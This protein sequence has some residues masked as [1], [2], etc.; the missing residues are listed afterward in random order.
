MKNFKNFFSLIFMLKL[1][2]PVRDYEV[3]MVFI[4]PLGSG[5]PHVFE[6]PD[7]TDLDSMHCK[8]SVLHLSTLNNP[9]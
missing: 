9:E 1:S 2:K 6:D 3:C 7:P 4:L 8:Q 5:D